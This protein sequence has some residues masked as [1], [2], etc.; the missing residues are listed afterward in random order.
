LGNMDNIGPAHHEDEVLPD[1]QPS[2]GKQES[3]ARIPPG[4]G[5]SDTAT[6]PQAPKV[7]NVKKRVLQ[8]ADREGADQMEVGA[9]SGLEKS[10][11]TRCRHCRLVGSR[12]R[13]HKRIQWCEA[14]D[15]PFNEW[16]VSIFPSKKAAAQARALS[17]ATQVGM[18][19]GRPRKSGKD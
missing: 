12:C 6:S 4:A 16:V 1:V 9:E 17:R 5:T 8:N 3:I 14:S 13:L 11:R 15:I 18:P 10:S 19:R 2:T 7:R